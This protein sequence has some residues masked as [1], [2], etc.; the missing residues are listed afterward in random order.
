MLRGGGE[1]A[2]KNY[3]ARA[4]AATTNISIDNHPGFMY[5]IEVR[6]IRSTLEIRANK[7]SRPRCD[8]A[9]WREIKSYYVNWR[10]EMKKYSL[11]A[12]LF[13][14]ALLVGAGCGSDKTEVGWINQLS[15]EGVSSIV[16]F[17]SNDTQN[18]TWSENL[19]SSGQQTVLKEVT[20]TTG[21]AECTSTSKG[22]NARIRADYDGNGIAENGGTVS[23]NSS[24]MY[25]I[26]QTE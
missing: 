6:E 20:K 26:T 21:Y 17:D 2:S 1:N 16:W 22:A 4:G 18:Q 19:A 3:T 13:A 23:E 8:E 10:T 12:T 9:R 7:A 15:G 24:T 11:W 5:V 25:T 14:V